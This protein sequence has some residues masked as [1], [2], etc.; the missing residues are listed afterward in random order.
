MHLENF[1][2]DKI[3]NGLLSAIVHLDKPHIAEYHE[4]RLR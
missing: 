2:V 3:K 4:N 1:Q